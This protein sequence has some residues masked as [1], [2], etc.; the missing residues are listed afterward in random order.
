[1]EY[2]SPL[3]TLYITADNGFITGI[4][5]VNNSPVVSPHDEVLNLCK[6]ELD[7][8]F[9]GTLRAFTVPIRAVGTPFR[10]RVWEELRKIPYGETISYKT[11]ANRINHPSAVRAVGGANHHN[12]INIIIP[13]HRVIGANGSLTGYGGGVE[14][15]LF[16]LEH[17]RKFKGVLTIKIMFV[18]LGNI[19]RSPMAEAIFR[20]MVKQNGLENEISVD[21][22]GTAGYHIGKPPHH[23]TMEILKAHGISYKGIFAEQLKKQHLKT[24]D[25]II[26]MDN[27]NLSD[28]LLLKDKNSTAQIKLLSDFVNGGWVSVPDPW[29][30]GDFELTYKLII[31]GCEMLLNY[32]KRTGCVR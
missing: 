31:Q 32:V 28:I 25:Y 29:Y 13:C 20:D 27:E 3:G 7:A 4:K 16:L 14:K 22:C 23:E 17:E 1:M 8:Y 18:C 6:A 9:A 5:Y 11:L 15:K 26:A 12:P 30:T 10:M 19:C 2:K 24:F 21:S